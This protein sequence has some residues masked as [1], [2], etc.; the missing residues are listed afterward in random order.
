MEATEPL[1]TLRRNAGYV[2]VLTDLYIDLL[3]SLIPGL[4][5]IVLGGG[6]LFASAVV[7]CRQVSPEACRPGVH[8]SRRLMP[9]TWLGPYGTVLIALVLGYVVGSVFYRQD[10]NLPDFKSARRIW[11]KRSSEE[12]EKLAVKPS[13]TFLGLRPID[14]QFPYKYMRRYLQRRGLDHLAAFIPWDPDRGKDLNKRTK[15]FINVLKIQLQSL[16]PEWCKEIVRNEAHVRMATSL[17]YASNWV[18]I[19]SGVS[20]VLLALPFFCSSRSSFTRSFTGTAVFVVVIFF[21]AFVIRF[22][23]EK[24]LHYLRVREVVYVLETAAFANRMGL[25]ISVPHDEEGRN[26]K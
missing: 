20:A 5:A 16:L 8:E 2:S 26:G 15:M 14:V 12:R 21:L 7:F 6:V 22:K 9:E 3:G 25:S 23:I 1:R 18:M 13:K 17:W 10:P 24:F 19:A 4:F 11:G